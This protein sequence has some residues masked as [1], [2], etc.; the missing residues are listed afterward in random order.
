LLNKASVFVSSGTEKNTDVILQGMQSILPFDISEMP[1]L[2]GVA[3]TV[4]PGSF[5]GVRVGCLMAQT[6]AAV[7]GSPM[8]ALSTCAVWAEV[9]WMQQ[10]DLDY[11]VVAMDA[12]MRETYWAVYQQHASGQKTPLVSPCLMPIDTVSLPD[13]LVNQRGAWVGS[14]LQQPHWCQAQQIPE[15]AIVTQPISADAILRSIW[16]DKPKP[17]APEALQPVY[18]R[19]PC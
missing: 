8:Y 11:V 13:D 2:E 5:S 7:T 9:A 12:R 1:R 4:G 15:T 6:I 16:Q 10:P 3:V 14:M 17:I 18:L 19:Q